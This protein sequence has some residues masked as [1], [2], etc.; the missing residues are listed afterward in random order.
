MRRAPL[1][2]H[3]LQFHRRGIL[4]AAATS[5][6]ALPVAA[7]ATRD[8][9]RTDPLIELVTAAR[10][11]AATARAVAT[12]FPSASGVAEVAKA[13]DTQAD[14]MQREIDRV[15]G[16]AADATTTTAAP[17]PPRVPPGQQ[18]AIEQLSRSLSD[19]QHKATKLVPSLPSYRA[20]LAGS[21]AAGCA[22]LVEVLSL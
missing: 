21:V 22:G 5:L 17:P 8:D 10:S 3:R 15:A 2:P 14:T 1:Q 4:L 13:R 16:G 7:C 9:S 19:A 11:D 12:H 6:V 18:A 20:G